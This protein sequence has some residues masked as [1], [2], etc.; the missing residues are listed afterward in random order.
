MTPSF[1]IDKFRKYGK[2]YG[3]YEGPSPIVVTKDPELMKSVLVKNFDSFQ[4]V[5]ELPVSV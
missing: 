1:Y 2:T 5:L 4:A 3:R